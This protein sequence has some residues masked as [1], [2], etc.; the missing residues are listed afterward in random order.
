MEYQVDVHCVFE[1]Q[2]LIDVKVTK[3]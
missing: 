2:T 3:R 1:S